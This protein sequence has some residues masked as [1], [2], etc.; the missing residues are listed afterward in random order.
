MNRLATLSKTRVHTLT[1]VRVSL[2]RKTVETDGLHLHVSEH[3]NC[4]PLDV[5]GGGVRSKTVR[6]AGVGKIRLN[7]SLYIDLLSCPLTF[8]IRIH[9]LL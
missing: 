1:H 7:I 2:M 5:L 6:R 8:D 4:S 9:T 3:A